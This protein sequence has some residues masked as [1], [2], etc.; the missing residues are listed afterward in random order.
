MK[1]IR[2][3]YKI[4]KCGDNE[5]FIDCGD[6][7]AKENITT[8]KIVKRYEQNGE[9]R[10]ANTI[11][12]LCDIFVCES[13]ESINPF[14]KIY[15]DFYEMLGDDSFTKHYDH[16][17]FYG[18]VNTKRKGFVYIAQVTDYGALLPRK[19]WDRV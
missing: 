17:N 5:R 19:L 4:E 18:A 15:N 14:Y 12:K 6:Y 2:I 10:I 11:W 7:I 16:Y 3:K 8:H 9:I 1:Y 13:G